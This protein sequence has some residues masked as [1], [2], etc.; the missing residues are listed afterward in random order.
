MSAQPSREMYE[1]FFPG[2]AYTNEHQLTQLRMLAAQISL[3]QNKRIFARHAGSHLSRQQGRGLELSELR[4]YQQG[5]DIRAID[6]RVTARTGLTHTRI[7]QEEKERPV[8]ILCDQR[9]SMFFG[10]QYSFKSVVAAQVASLLAW[11]ALQ[12]GDKVGA[13]LL[14]TEQVKDFNARHNAQHVLAIIRQLNVFNQALHAG[15]HK[16]EVSFGEYL[17]Q[18]KRVIKPGSSLYLISDFF[19]LT[20]SDHK[21]L[22]ELRRHTHI[23]ALQIL[24]PLERQ[25]PGSGQYLISDGQREGVISTRNNREQ[26]EYMQALNVWHEQQ[27]KVFRQLGIA[28]GTLSTHEPPIAALQIAMQMAGGK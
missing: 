19:D 5:D 25:L 10:S 2:G 14:G 24:D 28:M 4:E 3:G 23:Q 9:A 16:N 26:Q 18:V 12:Q 7:Y 6:W 1:G 27:A 8:F 21:Q 13:F 17:Q 11:A 15:Q 22:F 20:S